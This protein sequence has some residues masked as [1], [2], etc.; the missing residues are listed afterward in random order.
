MN[1]NNAKVSFGCSLYLIAIKFCCLGYFTLKKKILLLNCGRYKYLGQI[2][3][4]E[5]RE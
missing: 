3:H 5:E 2:T 4:G 1:S